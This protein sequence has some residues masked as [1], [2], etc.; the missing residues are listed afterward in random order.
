MESNAY[1]LSLNNLHPLQL[2]IVKCVVVFTI[3][4]YLYTLKLKSR[5][6]FIIELLCTN[7]LF[8]HFSSNNHFDTSNNT[9]LLVYNDLTLVRDFIA[10]Y[11]ALCPSSCEYPSDTCIL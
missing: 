8:Y 10:V 5:Q 1:I 9:A 3:K 7:I 2:W 6:I 4:L 11:Y